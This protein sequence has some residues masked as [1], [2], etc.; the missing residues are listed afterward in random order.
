MF[1]RRFEGDAATRWPDPNDFLYV[2]EC[3]RDYNPQP[4]LEKIVAPLYA[5]N[6]ADDNGNTLLMLAIMQ[7]H[8]E[9]ARL[10]LLKGANINSVNNNNQSPLHISIEENLDDIT[11]LLI[12]LGADINLVSKK[13]W[14]QVTIG[15]STASGGL[16]EGSSRCPR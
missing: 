11:H 4:H 16:S 5:V 7:T 1:E 6:S 8:S 9:L 12:N 2:Y 14:T 3:S 13:I 15:Q 10:L